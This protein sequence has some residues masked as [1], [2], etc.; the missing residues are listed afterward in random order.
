MLEEPLHIPFASEISEARL[1]EIEADID[2]IV[3]DRGELLEKITNSSM[4]F[5][6]NFKKMKKCST[7]E[8]A[9]KA[10]AE[11][12]RLEQLVVIP[13]SFEIHKDPE[14]PKKTTESDEQKILV[15]L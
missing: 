11:I 1:K 3:K 10:K 7:V 5:S 13:N 8:E 6:H 12:E 9:A 15:Q 4:Q 2:R 14:P